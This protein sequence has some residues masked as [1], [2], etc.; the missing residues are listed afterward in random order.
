MRPEE[1]RSCPACCTIYDC[2]GLEQGH[3]IPSSSHSSP[4]PHAQGSGQTCPEC[5]LQA[6]LDPRSSGVKRT[7]TRPLSSKSF[8]HN[9][10]DRPETRAVIR[11]ISPKLGENEESEERTIFKFSIMTSARKDSADFT[12]L[13]GLCSLSL[14]SDDAGA[15][16]T[17]L[18]TP[19]W[20]P[21][22]R[23][24]D[25]EARPWMPHPPTLCTDVLGVAAICSLATQSAAH[26]QR[27]RHHQGACERRGSSGPTSDTSRVRLRLMTRS[28]SDSCIV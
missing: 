13:R 9:W 3:L 15:E 24:P 23:P 10:R 28:P 22:R 18:L 12:V 26:R 20:I 4:K 5:L 1:L 7:E 25:L 14:S 19:S 17:R 21:K 27:Q 8:Q 16:P 11:T 6:Q 2:A